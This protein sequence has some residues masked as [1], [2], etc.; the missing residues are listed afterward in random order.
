MRRITRRAGTPEQGMPGRRML[1]N[2]MDRL[3]LWGTLTFAALKNM[4][5]DAD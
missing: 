5:W 2:P 3:R 1:S 4:H